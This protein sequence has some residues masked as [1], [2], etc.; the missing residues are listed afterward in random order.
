MVSAMFFG[1]QVE[2]NPAADV[3]SD[4]VALM[5]VE[6]G[7]FAVATP[8]GFGVLE[9]LPGVELAGLV[10]LSMLTTSVVTGLYVMVPTLRSRIGA[11]KRAGAAQRCPARPG[12]CCFRQQRRLQASAPATCMHF[13]LG[14][15]IDEIGGWM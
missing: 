8:F 12:H 9:A 11:G 13:A 4:V 6:P 10:V 7:R 1:G 5:T 15:V 2:K 14:M 3:T